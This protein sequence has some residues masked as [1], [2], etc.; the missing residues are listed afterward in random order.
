MNFIDKDKKVINDAYRDILFHLKEYLQQY[1]LENE[2]EY[3]K[4]IFNMLHRGFFS[5]NG[6]IRFDNNFNY[7]GLPLEVSQ[8][9]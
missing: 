9:I 8:G 3:S 4:I 2:L 1:N 7:L 5:M 6:V